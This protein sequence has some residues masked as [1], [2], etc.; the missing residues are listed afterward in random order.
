MGRQDLAR[1]NYENF[2]QLAPFESIASRAQPADEQHMNKV[3][4]YVGLQRVLNR[5]GPSSLT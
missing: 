5:Y 4:Y 1:R 2:L 3:L